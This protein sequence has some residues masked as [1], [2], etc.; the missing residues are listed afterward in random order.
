MLAFSAVIGIHFMA[1]D[2]GALTRDCV[3]ELA[4]RVLET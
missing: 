4:V 2:H 1:A 3:L